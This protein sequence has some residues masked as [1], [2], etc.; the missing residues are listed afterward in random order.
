M[1]DWLSDR[2]QDEAIRA[3]IRDA[4]VLAGIFEDEFQA[5]YRGPERS[6]YVRVLTE[7]AAGLGRIAR[8]RSDRPG[9]NLRGLKDQDPLHE[10]LGERQCRGVSVRRHTTLA[11]RNQ[12][13][14]ARETVLSADLRTLQLVFCRDAP[15]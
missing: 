13:R 10:R 15:L 1:H 12:R 8:G 11:D 7:I 3:A 2:P 5:T 6:E 9:G 4:A 14:W